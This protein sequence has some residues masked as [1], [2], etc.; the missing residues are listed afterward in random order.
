MSVFENPVGKVPPNINF[1]DRNKLTVWLC[2]TPHTSLSIPHTSHLTQ[3]ISNGALIF[4]DSILQ[5]KNLCDRCNIN[6]DRCDI[7]DKVN[8]INLYFQTLSILGWDVGLHDSDH[9]FRKYY[10]DYL[11]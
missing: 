4:I 2:P 7:N 11:D 5:D 9:F 10:E 6:C 1:L 8:Q 3:Y